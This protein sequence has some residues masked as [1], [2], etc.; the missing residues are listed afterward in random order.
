M[1]VS[2]EANPVKGSA[3]IAIGVDHRRP[4]P[5]PERS[6]PTLW[7]PGTPPSQTNVQE[8]VNQP[9]EA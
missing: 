8:L 9:K 3:I 4:T 1:C 7:R 6:G 5:T 2:P